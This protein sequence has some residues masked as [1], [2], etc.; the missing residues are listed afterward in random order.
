MYRVIIGFADLQDNKHSYKT[1]D[2]FPRQGVEVSEERIEALAS[3]NNLMRQ[4]LIREVK[5]PVKRER[6]RK[7]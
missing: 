7:K 3:G 1:G 6:K 2:V 5:E 4:P